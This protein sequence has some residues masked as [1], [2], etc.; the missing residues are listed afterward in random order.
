[1]T[2][3][4]YENLKKCLVEAAKE[5]YSMGYIQAQALLVI[6]AVLLDRVEVQKEKKKTV[7]KR[8]P[9]VWTSRG[10]ATLMFK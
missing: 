7:K 3:T 10:G 4:E 6:A 1:M 8:D 5:G 9:R 2:K